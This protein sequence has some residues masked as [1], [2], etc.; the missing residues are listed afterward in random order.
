VNHCEPAGPEP[1]RDGYDRFVDQSF[2]G[3]EAELALLA[4]LVD[5]VSA[6]VGGLLLVEGE[7]GIGKSS[8]LRAGLGNLR[9]AQGNQPAQGNSADCRVLWAAADELDQRFPL[10]L[11]EECLGAAAPEPEPAPA[12]TAA[13][14]VF[15]GDPVLAGV[16]RTLARVDRLCAVSP[17]VLVTEDLHWADE[18][19]VLVWS[20]L[21]RAVG[22]VPLLLVGSCRPGTGRED[23]E[24][25]RRGVATRGGHLAELGPLPGAQVAELVGGLV[26]GR[27]DQ[28]LA[29]VMGHAGGNPLY[30]RELADS[31]VRDG[32]IVVTEGVAGLAAVPAPVRVPVS[33]DAAIGERLAGLPEDAV[34]ALRWAAVLGAEFSV[35]DLQ[36]VSD[37]SA[38]DLM[39]I[40]GAA[41]GA[42]VLTEAGTRLVFRHGLIRQV[43]Y[44]GL[45]AALRAA[46]HL[47]AARALATGGADAERVAA[48]LAAAQ[49]AAGPDAEL[50]SDWA[51]G[52]LASEAPVLSYRAPQV[53]AELFRGVLARLDGDDDR[54]EILEASLAS[55]SFLLLRAEEVER[56]AGRLAATA[57]DPGRAA[58][59]AWLVAY[60]RMRTGRV[61][62]AD[63]IIEAALTRLGRITVAEA[64]LARLGPIPEA[65]R[66]VALRAV[67]LMLL[68]QFGESQ[69][70]ADEALAAAEASGD[71]LAAGYA[72]HAMSMVKTLLRDH[73]AGLA[74]T[75][76]AL[77]V[78]GDDPQAI[79]LRI[80]V[81]ANRIA[82][83]SDL[84]RWPEAAEV[85]RRGLALAEQAGTPRIGTARQILG[86]LHFING[87][88]DDAVAE[89]EPAVGLPGPDFLPLLI[90]GLLALIAAHRDDWPGAEERLRRVPDEL[91]D[92]PAALGNSHYFL[93]AKA[94]VA[95]RTGQPGEAIGL[96]ATALSLGRPME[97]MPGRLVLLTP[98]T[99]L[100]LAYHDTTT[101]ALAA[102]AARDEAEREPLP[103][104]IAVAEHCEGLVNGDPAL[105]QTAVRYFGVSGR[106]LSQA[107]A[108]EDTAA[109]LAQQD[110]VAAARQAQAAALEL[111]Q[112]LGAGWDVRRAES[113]LRQYG[114]RR[115]RVSGEQRRPQTGW[116]ALTP[117]ETKVAALVAEGRSNPDIAAHLFLSRNTVQTH[118]SHILGK[119]GARSRAEIIRVAMQH[120]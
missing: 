8:L 96:L 13:A 108:L 50:A 78:I 115:P 33:L 12:L 51:A 110:G 44:E 58:E 3:R 113:R 82:L 111:Y 90:A 18:A 57:R 72:H 61:A 99:R 36:L 118:V 105:T 74:H 24:R 85:G 70:A 68:G 6:G 59:M 109:L 91:M 88:W 55:V 30:A 38:G 60:S 21:V 19:S 25:L 35:T 40:I 69:R 119:L 9:T 1:S 17:V 31:L 98:L 104:K 89:L 47:Q 94:M 102:A 84:D 87:Q 101:A 34:Q 29:E 64:T 42:G 20:R 4:R 65:A 103:V 83:L 39:G 86:N 10:R 7:Q 116:A 23:L 71:R 77:A 117:T 41:I 45:P 52:W 73:Q 63:A 120:S 48:Q 81:M 32:R 93:M 46:L 112:R 49:L 79:D 80:L 66:L 53:A 67:T 62:E 100:A 97:A 11:M 43:L 107:E 75:G 16:E 114:A 95:E 22:Q 27:P 26:G 76:H 14:G 106:V 28:R 2:V 15:A 54:R 92:H 37:Q 56:I 5:A